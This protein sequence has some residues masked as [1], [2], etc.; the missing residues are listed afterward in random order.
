M[1]FTSPSLLNLFLSEILFCQHFWWSKKI[2]S[3]RFNSNIT[4]TKYTFWSPQ[5][6]VTSSSFCSYSSSA[7]IFICTNLFFVYTWP[8][9]HTVEN[10]KITKMKRTVCLTENEWMI[11]NENISWEPKAVGLEC[12]IKAMTSC[13]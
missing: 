1:I 5:L 13:E 6:R 3:F 10:V 4:S 2:F 7:V 8:S 12:Q 11:K 9:L